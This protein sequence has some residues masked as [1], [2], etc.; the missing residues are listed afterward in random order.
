[1]KMFTDLVGKG[2]G[3]NKKVSEAACA[4]NI[5]RQMFHLNIMQSYSGPIKKSKVSTVSFS[6]FKLF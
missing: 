3:S 1:M 5:V 4:M 6:E 2:T